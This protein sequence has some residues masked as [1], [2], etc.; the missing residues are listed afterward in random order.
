MT[1]A[2]SVN[3]DYI[4]F[5][6]GLS[7]LLLATRAAMLCGRDQTL[8]WSGLL[9]FGLL[10][11]LN[12]W[13][14][15]LVF[16][17]GD[18]PAF[19]AARLIV[20]FASFLPL[21]EFG[22]RGLIDQGCPRLSVWIYLPLLVVVGWI[23]W[24]DSSA[25]NAAGRYAFGLPG[26]LLAGAALWR[27][28][29]NVE[30]E[31]RFGLQL[32]A[33]SMLIYALATGLIV[34]SAA[35]FPANGLSQERF[36]AATGLPIQALRALCGFGIM[37]GIWLYG[38]QR[39]LKPRRFGGIVRWRYPVTFIAL[40]TLGWNVTEWRGHHAEKEMRE[41]LLRQAVE[42]ARNLPLDQV[43]ALSF[44][45]TDRGAPAFE[46]LRELLI[47]YG[48]FVRQH[49]IYTMALRDGVI[50]FGPENLVES[51][52]WAS[53][54]GTVYQQPAPE[55][56]ELFR[57]GKPAT[58][59]PL[60]D[61]F[62]TFI[63]A[64][65]PVL[66]P[67][68]GQVL[69]AVGV[70]IS[71]DD[72]NVLIAARRLTPIVGTLLLLTMLLSGAGA[73][74]WRNRQAAARRRA[75]LRQ[76]ETVL[77]GILGLALT[78][79]A[80][81]LVIEVEYRERSTFFHR[82]ADAHAGSIREVFENTQTALAT[83]NQFYQASQQ[84]DHAEFSTFTAHLAKNS[85]VEAYQWAPRIVAT[86]IA[87][88]ETEARQAG[89]DDFMIWERN[90]QGERA[91]V[92]GRPVYYPI[93]AVEPLAGHQATLGFDLGAEPICRAVLEK[94]VRTGLITVTGPMCLPPES[95]PSSTLLVFQPV[96]AATGLAADHASDDH[97]QPVRGFASVV[98]DLQAL[99]DRALLRGIHDPGEIV[100]NLVD[101]TAAG[102]ATL[103]AAYPQG[104]ES[105]HIEA[106]TSARFEQRQFHAVHPLFAFGHPYAIVLHPTPVFHAA[107]PARAGWL[108]GVAGL[109][110]T[111]AL[112][113]FVGF[114]RSRQ[115]VLEQQVQA[116]TAELQESEQQFRSYYDLGLIGMAI[117]VPTK[118]WV[119]FNDRLC[120]ILGYSRAD[121]M[122]KTWSEITHPDDLAADITQFNRVMAGEIEGYT[123]DKRFIR[124][125]GGIVYTVLSV[126]I[127]RNPDGSPLHF[128]AM[129]QD[130]TERKALEL[131]LRRLATTD[132]L[133][134]LD[135]R[136]HFLAQVTQEL[137]RFKRYAKPTALLM[138][139]L[140]HF[141]RVN[142]THGHA[143]GDAVLRHCATVA[144]QILRKVDVMGRLGGEEFAALL[145]GT[146]GN[147][148]RLLAERLRQI[149]ADSPTPA[150]GGLIE[151]TASIGVTL[152][153]LSDA[154]ADTVLARAD[155]A[156]YRAKDQGRN[157][158]EIELP[159][160]QS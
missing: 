116:R 7:F 84:V 70:D 107:H 128:V 61:E 90:P 2:F 54:P 111:V 133:T 49:S 43:R 16:S 12:E 18:T 136:R 142:D 11:S 80:T 17:L 95:K 66:D 94:A 146:D 148:A 44:T 154:A 96:F 117:T 79:A 3:M 41:R 28:A 113:A 8:A 32:A 83:L 134:D 155:R 99:L 141:K 33:V 24:A 130:I 77:V 5:I 25:L 76:F 15:L 145:P 40:L 74:Q 138:I 153:A 20:L 50:V 131:E 125:D 71:I 118:G 53:P 152:F 30:R 38:Q 27:A 144:R 68:T 101:L 23:G 86:E 45:A 62:G 157:R 88:F 82:L 102:G 63:S 36:L 123:L 93:Y 105:A 59:G 100:V 75:S 106:I 114:L 29:G 115:A 31:R 65:A 69:M 158:V 47:G 64:I 1:N 149:I 55:N 21:L 34:P 112:T 58:L 6:Y 60:K 103:L 19:Y 85:T 14:D 4:Y 150:A 124:H 110:L 10:H 91:S 104:A 137:A 132:A 97:A 159:P 122:T 147:G 73:I 67:Q 37:T 35:F 143:A 109:L 26:G 120:Q 129:V 139:D 13:L 151:V 52:P 98:L 9:I 39:P 51:D 46:H 42:I 127:V 140:D 57:T 89:L 135:N 87:R 92:S 81:L 126:R 119:Q 156:L 108:T 56:F 22:R 72:W 78:V 160:Q 121:L 48:R